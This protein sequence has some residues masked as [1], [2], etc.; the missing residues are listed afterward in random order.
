MGP[1]PNPQPNYQ[2]GQIL[3]PRPISP[4]LLSASAAAL[5]SLGACTWEPFATY[6]WDQP[7][8]SFLFA[9]RQNRM[10]LDPCRSVK[11]DPGAICGIRWGLLP[12]RAQ[13]NM[14]YFAQGGSASSARPK[15]TS[16]IYKS[17][18]WVFP[19][20]IPLLWAPPRPQPRIESADPLWPRASS[21]NE[22]HR[23]DGRRTQPPPSFL[24]EGIN[25]SSAGGLGIL[26]RKLR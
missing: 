6:R 25:G 15:R 26:F 20:L 7:V 11:L 17:M 13:R 3:H 9:D 19:P 14:S 5:G 24:L 18:A 2:Q 8:S 23:M 21:Q 10:P 16:P 12:A 4:H 1:I 22:A